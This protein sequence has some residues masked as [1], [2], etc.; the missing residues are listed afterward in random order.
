MKVDTVFKFTFWFLVIVTMES[1]SCANSFQYEG[2]LYSCN[3][4]KNSL[5]FP[6]TGLRKNLFI[7]FIWEPNTI[8]NDKIGNDNNLSQTHQVFFNGCSSSLVQ[9]SKSNQ[10]ENL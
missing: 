1:C 8:V 4:N 5:K 6:L 2:G 3:Y 7:N 9:N 10:Y